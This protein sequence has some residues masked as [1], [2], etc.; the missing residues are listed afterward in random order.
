M[1]RD[2][3]ERLV[4]RLGQA[5]W[6][7][8]ERQQELRPFVLGASDGAVAA[9]H[10]RQPARDREAQAGAVV[11]AGR[12]GIDLAEGIEQGIDLAR[13]DADAGVAHREADRRHRRLLGRFD[14][15]GHN[16]VGGELEGVAEQVEQ[17]L[18]DLAG[19]ADHHAQLL[20]HDQLEPVAVALVGR[21]ARDDRF[22]QFANV[23]D[24]ALERRPARIQPG[25]VENIVDH[26][27]QVASRRLDPLEIRDGGLIAGL[28]RIFLQQHRI[29]ED[30][31]ERR[32]QLMAHLGEEV[33]LGD[34]LQVRLL[35]GALELGDGGLGFAREV[36]HV[37]V[38]DGEIRLD[39]G[40]A[41]RP[42]A[43]QVQAAVADLLRHA[44]LG[45]QQLERARRDHGDVGGQPLDR[46]QPDQGAG[47]ERGGGAERHGLPGKRRQRGD[48]AD[49]G[50][51]RRQHQQQIAAQAS[52]QPAAQAG[53]HRRRVDGLAVAGGF[54][55]HRR[56]LEGR[57][58]LMFMPPAGP[59][60]PAPARVSPRPS[61]SRS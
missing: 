40:A 52:R 38:E 17:A 15:Q 18:A 16:S 13:I 5:G 41:G 27:E 3:G 55:A 30:R 43:V 45:E 39:L 50:A 36:P 14:V 54:I 6:A 2:R 53:A 9:H 11:A 49:A 47:G 56:P 37:P 26:G 19:V 25:E 57:A 31:V 33:G 12:T 35:A 21:A 24:G 4:V 28:G 20:G 60:G 44:R 59:G 7:E 34:V 61:G 8:R 42:L 29:A 1:H 58:R 23:D 46:D 48:E 51:D 22:G 10:P 32:A